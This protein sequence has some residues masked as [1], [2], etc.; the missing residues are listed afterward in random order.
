[1]RPL[2]L[3]TL[4][5]VLALTA[6]AVHAAPSLQPVGAG[7]T[8]AAPKDDDRPMPPAPHRTAAMQ[9][10]AAPT[11]QWYSS[12]VFAAEPEALF[13]QP[14]TVKPTRAGLEFAL[15][16]KEVVP[17]VRRDVEIRYP[18]RDALV[19]SPLAFEPG[20][21]RLARADDWS[22]D[23]SMAQGDDEMLATVAHGSPFASIRLSR[24]DLRVRLPAPGVRLHPEADARALAL[25]VGGKAYALFGP[26]G[27]RWEP[28]S[29]TDWIARMP[30]G[31]GYLA[32][33]ALPDAAAATLRLFADHAY[34]FITGTRVD[35]KVDAGNG[36]VVTGF[37]ARTQAMEGTQRTPLLGL[38]PH[39]WFRNTSVEDRL[40]PGY[41][42]V[43]GR[44]RLLPAARFETI[45]TYHGFVPFWPAVPPSARS[46][47]LRELIDKDMRSARRMML[48][49]GQG[50]YWQG[51][52]LLRN[53]ELA[54]VAEH[55]GDL[56]ARDRLVA[57]VKRR[58]EEWFSGRSDRGYFH[59][60][61]A[62]GA[63]AS[64]PDEFFTV[65]QIND[66]HFT[67]GYWIRAAA[68]IA[69]RDPAWAA[70][71]RWGGMVDLLVADIATRERGR[72]DFPFLR[73]FDPY[74][75]HS[76]ASGI[77]LGAY[78]NNQEASSEAVNAWAALVLWGAATGDAGLVE[79]G[80]Y[81][82]TTEIEA[83]RHYWFDVHALVFP[84]EYRNVEASMVFGG[85][86]AHNTWWT[87]EPRQIKGI[88][89]LPV[90]TSST[91]L[92]R[93]PTFVRR[94]LGALAGETATYEQYGR[95]PD[96]APPKDVWQDIFA[97]YQ[98]L[99]D[100][101]AGLAAWDRWGAVELGDSRSATLHWLLSL[102]AMGP[103]DFGVT[104]DTPLYA[105]FQ[106]ADGHRTYLAYNARTTPVTVR[107]SDGQTLQ[108]AP[109]S[110]G[111]LQ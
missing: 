52:G 77:G 19:I 76:W 105:V 86:Y 16:S 55:Q 56:A 3:H 45:A 32:A 7:A 95:R 38:Y 2:R 6:A 13:V 99:A 94:N 9:A 49:Q 60:D 37:E 39:H 36:R 21:A 90:T 101:A 72:A 93:D 66:H 69:L 65:E 26:T 81:L 74:E 20:R 50:A 33:A 51:K 43:R 42:T 102:D 71:E 28:Q 29:D 79:L 27:V 57:M 70:K 100:P 40:G 41:D 22:I 11:N 78:G 91:Y 62:I 98:A 15:P 23:I 84:P 80:Q 63:V 67:Y 5:L 110:L 88:N 58:M 12:L 35:W 24:G 109:R 53:L 104:A 54:D 96:N 31:R 34:A 8:L 92:G 1:M 68:E 30:A 111:R 25:N 103:P 4:A 85:Q 89:L 44:V 87:D 10:L 61:R 59:Y 14:I 18:H 48:Q 64:Y 97:K 83:V 46:G 17:T 82:M 108:V 106:R 107:F 47:E 75:G 73:T